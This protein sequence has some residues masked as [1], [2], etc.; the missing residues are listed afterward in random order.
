[1]AGIAYQADSDLCGDADLWH[2][3][4][5]E[6]VPAQILALMAKNFLRIRAP[7]FFLCR[8]AVKPTQML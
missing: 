5:Y 1:M 8:F 3:G 6:V 7:K 2:K 4:G